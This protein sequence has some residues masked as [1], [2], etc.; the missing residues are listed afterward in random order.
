[1]KKHFNKA[2]IIVHRNSKNNDM[3][4][5]F[6][7]I[8]KPNIKLTPFRVSKLGFVLI[9]CSG[10]ACANVFCINM[11]FLYPVIKTAVWTASHIHWDD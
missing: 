7:K 10:S 4:V 2:T 3:S 5:F 11:K 1:M 6:K 9:Q 8:N